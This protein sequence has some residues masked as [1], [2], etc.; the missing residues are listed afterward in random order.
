MHPI[1][2]SVAVS[3]AALREALR[4]PEGANPERLRQTAPP[5]YL[6]GD[7]ESPAPSS[8]HFPVG[9]DRVL[10]SLQMLD[11]RTPVFLLSAAHSYFKA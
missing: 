6:S 9:P 3:V 8:S 1:L 4:P 10:Q 5:G 7:N 2:S 11:S